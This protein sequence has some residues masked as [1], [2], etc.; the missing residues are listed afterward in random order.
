MVIN[1]YAILLYAIHISVVYSTS[2]EQWS[3]FELSLKGPSDGNPFIDYYL[4]GYFNCNDKPTY[5]IN[6]F[7]NGNGI[8]KIRFM[9]NVIGEC[10]YTIFSNVN[11]MNNIKGSFT[12]TTP[13]STFNFGPVSVDYSTNKSFIFANGKN[14]FPIGTTSYYFWI[15][16]DLEW[17]NQT[18]NELQYLAENDYFNK[19]RFCIF[20][21]AGDTGRPFYYPYQGTP[22]NQWGNNNKFNVTF[23]KHLDYVLNRILSFN[24]TMI[25]DIILFHPYDGGY[26][27]FDCLGCSYPNNTYTLCPNNTYNTSNDELYL[28]YI[29]S[30]IGS[31][32]NVWYN[33][34]NEFSLVNTKSK[35]LPNTFPIWDK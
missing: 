17:V 13:T 16:K 8:Y 6:G 19:V 31:Y 32:R 1:C 29:T 2:I 9:P 35:G 24:A 18:L 30:R 33:L 7:Y 5:T 3:Q 23:F 11:N 28:K 14:Y 27:G 22:P 20:P 10:N 21:N 26:Y 34:C 4:T 25:V 12:V 15:Y